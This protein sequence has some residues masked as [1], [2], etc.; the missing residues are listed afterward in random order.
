MIVDRADRSGLAQ[1]Y[2]LRGRV[3][4]ARASALRLPALPPA[5]RADRGGARRALEALADHTELGAGFQIAMRDL[6]LRGAGNL[7]GAEQSGHVA[8]SASSST[9]RCSTRRW[10]RRG[11]DGRGRRRRTGPPRRAGRRLPARDLHPLRGGQDRRPPAHRRRRE[12][13]ELR[14]IRDE[15]E[16]RFG[17]PPPRGREPAGAAAGADRTRPRR[18]A[19]RRARGGRLSVTGIELDPEQAG[20]SA[21]RSRA[22]C[23]SGARRRPRRCRRA[24]GARAERPAAV[25]TMAKGLRGGGGQHERGGAD[26]GDAARFVSPSRER[27]PRPARVGPRRQGRSA[28]RGPAPR[29]APRPLVFGVA[30][31]RALRGVAIAEGLGPPSI[32]SGASRS[33]RTRPAHAEASRQEF[34]QDSSVVTERVQV[35]LQDSWP[36]DPA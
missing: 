30:L 5:E 1:L 24:R 32:P 23:T 26:N 35:R 8:A 17:P 13:G 19:Q 27:G 14:A 16:D 10:P 21:S 36:P 7:L 2:Q 12:P 29:A 31:R 33:S 20:R 22:R 9:A 25:L 34:T 3:G 28:D 18:R 6:E 11:A 4:R 15:L